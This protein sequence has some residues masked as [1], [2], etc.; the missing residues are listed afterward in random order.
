[1]HDQH[2]AP[3]RGHNHRGSRPAA[4]WQTPHD[5]DAPTRSASEGT[6]DFDLIERAFVE[7]FERAEDPTSFLRLARVPFEAVAADGAA[8]RLLR[9]ELTSYVDLGS[10]TPLFNQNGFRYAPLPRLLVGRRRAL[11]LHYFDGNRSRA[12][13][14]A[15]ALALKAATSE[16]G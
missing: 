12:L 3:G 13:R 11:R 1:M 15:E 9:V 4:Q 2:D 6:A 5:P 14:L 16:T 8:L 7:G 10:L